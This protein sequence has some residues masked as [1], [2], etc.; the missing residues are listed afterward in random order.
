MLLRSFSL[1]GLRSAADLMLW[2]IGYDLDAFGAS[3]TPSL[4]PAS[5]SLHF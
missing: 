5:A 2:R 3:N 1:M 4:R